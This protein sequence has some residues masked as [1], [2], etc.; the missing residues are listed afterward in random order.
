[1]VT[2]VL[3]C[4]CAANAILIMTIILQCVILNTLQEVSMRYDEIPKFKNFS[5]D[6]NLAYGFV[7]YM[8]FIHAAVQN[9]GL[10]M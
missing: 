4:C 2:S 5:I 8:N 10:Q 1:M 3:L 7:G 9:Q 6:T